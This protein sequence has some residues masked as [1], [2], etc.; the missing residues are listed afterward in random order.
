MLLGSDPKKFNENFHDPIWQEAIDE[1][2]D[3]LDE[4]KTWELVSLPLG[5]KL[6]Q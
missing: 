1:E 6:V 3:S 5:R 2:F 4:K